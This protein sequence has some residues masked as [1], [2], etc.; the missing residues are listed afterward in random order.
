MDILF[1]TTPEKSVE[2]DSE[3]FKT[4]IY[5]PKN[6]I[7]RLTWDKE[8]SSVQLSHNG[9][10]TDIKNLNLVTLKVD[11]VEISFTGIEDFINQLDTTIKNL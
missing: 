9:G 8:N 1:F 2:L 7:R 4:I 6:N 3:T 11:G 5:N 10:I